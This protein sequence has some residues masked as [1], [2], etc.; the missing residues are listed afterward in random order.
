MDGL[1][2]I[3][4]EVHHHLHILELNK[5]RHHCSDCSSQLLQKKGI[6]SVFILEM[7]Q[8]PHQHR[9]LAY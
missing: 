6:T 1:L 8:I 2:C 9:P 3:P 4:F 7:V 5:I